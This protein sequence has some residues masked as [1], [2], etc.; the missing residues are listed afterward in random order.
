MLPQ[1]ADVVQRR[2]D[3]GRE[4]TEKKI[5]YGINRRK[6]DQ[7]VISKNSFLKRR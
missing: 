4:F 6:R 1:G 2:H 7:G 5:G 3:M